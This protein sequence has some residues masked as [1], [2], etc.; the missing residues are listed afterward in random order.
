MIDLSD[1][2]WLRNRPALREA[3]RLV[4]NLPPDDFMRFCRLVVELRYEKDQMSLAH[5]AERV[6]KEK[7]I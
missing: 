4:H 6:R 3:V 2:T 5:V 1:E 7:G